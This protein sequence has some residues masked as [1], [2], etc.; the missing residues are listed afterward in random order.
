MLRH[1]AVEPD[2]LGLGAPGRNRAARLGRWRVVHMV[3]RDGAAGQQA[4]RDVLTF[5]LPSSRIL[6]NW[7][8]I[9]LTASSERVDAAALSAILGLASRFRSARALGDG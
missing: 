9:R 2:G 5:I 4:D 6:N 3:A 1:R 8:D 7:H